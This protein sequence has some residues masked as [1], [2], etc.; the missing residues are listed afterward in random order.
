MRI[1]I[2]SF[3][4]AIL[5]FEFFLFKKSHEKNIVSPESVSL[6]THT[7]DNHLF[8]TTYANSNYNRIN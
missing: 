1:G 4:F 7:I 6:D 2:V 5:F 8:F 3:C